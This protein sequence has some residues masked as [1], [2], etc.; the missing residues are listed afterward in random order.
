MEILYEIVNYVYQAPQE[1]RNPYYIWKYSMR[2]HHI[3]FARQVLSSRNPYYIW[4][5]SMSTLIIIYKKSRKCRNPY[6]IWKYSM[7]EYNA[8]NV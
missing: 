7:S 2:Q 6:Y 5:Y 4:K 8:W 3:P 1:C